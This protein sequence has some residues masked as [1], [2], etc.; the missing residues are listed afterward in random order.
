MNTTNTTIN[1][2]VLLHKEMMAMTWLSR[3]K[4]LGGEL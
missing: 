3:S 1:P 2:P 4:R